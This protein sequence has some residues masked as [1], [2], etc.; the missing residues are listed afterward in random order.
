MCTPTPDLIDGGPKNAL[1]NIN[2]LNINMPDKAG[3]T[4]KSKSRE[5]ILGP[6]TYSDTK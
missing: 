1:N 5:G 4:T 3:K 2:V 6:I